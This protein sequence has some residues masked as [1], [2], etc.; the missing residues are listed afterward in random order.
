[1]NRQDR[2]V[3]SREYFSDERLAEHHFR[4]FNNFLDRGM[5]EVVDERRRS[6]PIS[7]TKG[8]K[9]PSTSN[10]AMCGWSLRASAKPTAPKAAVP[11]EARLRNIT[12][13]APVFMEMSIVRGGEDEPE[14]VVDT[15]E[16]KVGR[17]PIMVGSNKCNMAGFSDDELIDIGEDPSTPA[18]TSSST[19]PS[20]C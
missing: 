16:T 11:Q 3:V 5:Q 9:S 6:R 15:T 20:A 8:A 4:S 2:R 12:Y 1:M 14:Q 7:A 19:A 10:S 13:S 18:A 17:M